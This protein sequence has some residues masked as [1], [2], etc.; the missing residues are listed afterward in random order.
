MP[1][2]DKV[3][4]IL[5][6]AF[7]SITNALSTQ[8]KANVVLAI[9]ATAVT[10]TAAGNELSVGM[11]TELTIDVI[12]TAISG[13]GTSYQFIIDRKEANGEW[14]AIYVATAITSVYS[15]ITTQMGVGCTINFAFGDIIRIRDYIESTTPSITRSVSIIGK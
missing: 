7:N 5:G 4:D 9:P 10:G 14:L 6:R 1:P 13:V 15:A 12:A 8:R 2:M 3:A 11:Y